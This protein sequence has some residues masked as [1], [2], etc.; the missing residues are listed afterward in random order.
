MDNVMKYLQDKEAQLRDILQDIED[1]YKRA[2][3]KVGVVD[4][5][6]VD[7]E[8]EIELERF[9]AVGMVKKYKELQTAFRLRRKYKD[10]TEFLRNFR[11]TINV[12]ELNKS[13]KSINSTYNS[14]SNRKYGLRVRVETRAEVLAEFE[15]LMKEA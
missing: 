15:E 11:H 3:A 7:I 6:I 10:D 14:Q 8:H 1:E 2:Y 4:K 12:K 9:D 13:A 5:I